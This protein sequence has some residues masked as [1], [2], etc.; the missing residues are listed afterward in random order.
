M[1]KIACIAIILLII[2]INIVGAPKR[3]IVEEKDPVTIEDG[4]K[5]NA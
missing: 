4:I 2:V 5:L 1:K 3:Y